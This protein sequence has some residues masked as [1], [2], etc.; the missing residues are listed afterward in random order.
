MLLIRLFHP[1][2]MEQIKELTTPSHIA[3]MSMNLFV[4]CLLAVY[5][6]GDFECDARFKV[7]EA[8]KYGQYQLIRKIGAG[9]MGEVHLVE[10][11]LLKRP[12]ALKL[13]KTNESDDDMAIARFEPGSPHDSQLDPSEYDRD[14]R[15]RS[16]R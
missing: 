5:G 10:H 13:I 11:S 14:L 16:Y 1:E 15:L 6:G 12:C 9:G 8:E 2:L 7:H 3:S 4:A